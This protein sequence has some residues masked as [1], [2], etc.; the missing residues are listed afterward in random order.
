MKRLALALALMLTGGSAL[1]TEP[2]SLQR[3]CGDVDQL[4]G[5]MDTWLT[6]TARVDAITITRVSGNCAITRGSAEQLPA[7][8]KFGESLSVVFICHLIE[9]D[10]ETDQG[11]FGF[12]WS[13]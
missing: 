4:T 9:V 8:F 5:C 3:R 2:V 10:L 12:W 13:D 1:A 6:I 7:S 11:R